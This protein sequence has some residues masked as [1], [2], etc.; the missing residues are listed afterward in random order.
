LNSL[1]YYCR[2]NGIEYNKEMSFDEMTKLA[3][4]YI[5]FRDFDSLK[6]IEANI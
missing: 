5:G 6:I 2:V 4:K 1:S 3:I